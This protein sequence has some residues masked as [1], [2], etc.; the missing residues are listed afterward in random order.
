MHSTGINLL[1][2][3]ERKRK[4]HGAEYRKQWRKV[5]LGIDARPL[6]IWVIEVTDT[7]VGDALMLPGLLAPIPPHEPIARVSTDGAYNTKGCLRR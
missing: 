2:E 5:H 7:C 1:G 4:K 3:R 6:E